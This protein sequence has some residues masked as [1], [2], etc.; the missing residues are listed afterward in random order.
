MLAKVLSA[1]GTESERNK[2]DEYSLLAR[3]LKDMLERQ[4][5][6]TNGTDD[7]EASYDRLVCAFFR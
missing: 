5:S 6:N 7:E 2:V 3:S 4:G 1:C